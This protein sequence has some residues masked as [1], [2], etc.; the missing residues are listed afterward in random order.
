[1]STTEV[2]ARGLEVIYDGE[3]PFCSS[4]VRLVRLREALGQVTLIDARSDHPLVAQVVAM[5]YDLDEGMIVRLDG[6]IHHGADAMRLLTA[7][8]TPSPAFNRMMRTLFASPARAAR[9]YPVLRSGRNFVL[10][11]LGRRKIMR[12]KRG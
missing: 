12:S 8:S 11:L 6:R 5:G 9:L 4:Y 1:M 7:L 10:R 2:P 3:C